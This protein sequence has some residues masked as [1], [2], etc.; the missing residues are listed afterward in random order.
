VKT[1]EYLGKRKGN[2]LKA[3]LMNFKLITKIKTL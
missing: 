3:K 1:E 2:I